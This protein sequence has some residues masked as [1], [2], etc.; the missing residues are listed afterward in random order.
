MQRAFSNS[1]QSRS[2]A[3]SLAACTDP[4][5]SAFW[6]NICEKNPMHPSATI[7]RTDS[8]VYRNCCKDYSKASVEPNKIGRSGRLSP[9]LADAES[10]INLYLDH[11]ASSIDFLQSPESSRASSFPLWVI[12]AELCPVRTSRLRLSTHV[13]RTARATP[14]WSRLRPDPD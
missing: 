13:Q 9:A 7:G 5:D 10:R 14:R 11:S 6:H 12:W 1:W 8:L 4:L 2:R 3:I